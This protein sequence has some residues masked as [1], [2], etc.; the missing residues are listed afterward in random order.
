MNQKFLDEYSLT[1]NET[2][3]DVIKE[4]NWSDFLVFWGNLTENYSIE[5]ILNLFSYN[6]HGSV[7]YTFDEWN[8]STIDRRIKRS[9]K[10]IPILKNGFKTYV[11]DIKQTYQPKTSTQSFMLWYNHHKVDNLLIDYYENITDYKTPSNDS[12]TFRLYFLFL[13]QYKKHI[14]NNYQLNSKES[15][16]VYSSLAELLIVKCNFK[17]SNIPI[18]SH[19][20]IRDL[21]QDSLM[22]C[23]QIINK[24]AF[25]LF[26]EVK[27]NINDLE[28][29]YKNLRPLLKN[30]DTQLLFK[31]KLEELELNTKI[32]IEFINQLWNNLTSVSSSQIKK[33]EKLIDIVEQENIDTQALENDDNT[34]RKIEE[35]NDEIVSNLEKVEY[36]SNK[37]EM[38]QLS[39]FESSEDI[40]SR[41][42]CEIFNGFETIYQNTFEIESIE[43]KRWEHIKSKEKNLSV[44]LTSEITEI[45]RDN[46]FTYFNSN[47]DEEIKLN[48][49]INNNL[50]LSTLMVDKDFSIIFSPNLIHIYWHNFEKKQYDLNIDSKALVTD[51]SNYILNDENE[52]A[53]TTSSFQHIID[54]EDT[55]N[56][57]LPPID[58]ITKKSKDNDVIAYLRIGNPKQLLPSLTYH[59]PERIEDSFGAKGHFNDNL[60]AIKLLKQIENED[61]NAT[62]DEQ[63]IL[64]KYIGWGAMPSSFDENDK[65]WKKEYHEL[66]SLLTEE[67]YN[68]ARESTLTSFY[69]PTI[70]IDAMYKALQNMGFESGNLFDPCCATG[71]FFG[72][73]P[74]DLEKCKLYGV[75]KDSIS[76]R[77]AKLLYPKAN[78]EVNS[79]ED[80]PIEDN[81]FDVSIGNVPFGNFSVFD[82]RYKNNFLI[83]DYFFQKTIDKT[84]PNGL[85]AFITSS[86]TLDKKDNTIRKYIAQR[87]KFLGAIRLPNDT[88]SKNANTKVT[89][90][91]IFLQ[92]REELELDISNEEWLNIVENDD[93]ISI[94]QY[95]INHPNMML[96]TMEMV[97]SQFG[98]NSVLKPIENQD[99]KVSLNEAINYLPKNIFSKPKYEISNQNTDY[100]IL[101]VDSKIKND[102]FVIKI[103]NGK[104][105]IYQRQFSSLVP[106]TIQDGIVAKRIIELTKIKDA[107]KNNFEIQLKNGSDEELKASQEKLHLLYDSFIKKYG[108]INDRVNIRAYEE[109]PDCYLLTSIENM[110]RSDDE[111]EK[112]S[113]SKGDVFFK[114]T[115]NKPINIEV[116][117]SA[118]EALT[119]SM[120]QKGRV[121]IPFMKQLYDVSEEQLIEELDNLIYKDPMEENRYVTSS[122]YLSG[123][124]KEKLNIAE[125]SNI[126]G[127]YERNIIALTEVLP[128]KI[129]Y[130]DISVTLGS[131][132]I[133][134]D[135]YCDFI[136]QLLD[137]QY[138]LRNYLKIHYD[139]VTN[140]WLFQAANLYGRTIKNTNTWGTSRADALMIIK[141]TLN[142]KNITIFDKTEDEKFVINQNETIAAREKQELIKQ[143]F[144][145]WIW[146]DDVR[147]ERLVDI[148]NDTFN[149]IVERKY[150]GSN[151]EFT[152]MNPSVTL[153]P[154]QKNAVARVLLGGNTL[155]AHCVGAGKTYECIASVME[156]KKLQVINKPL[157]VVPNG[158]LGQWASEFLKLYPTANVLVATNKDFEVSR[159]RRLFG[160]IATGEW[161]AVI[162]AHSSFGLIPMSKEYQKEHIISEQKQ[163]IN[164]IQQIE[165][166]YGNNLSVKKLEQKRKSLDLKL[167]TLLDDDKKDIILNFEELGVD[168]LIV[169]EAHMFKNLPMYSKM[170]NVSGVN[171]CDSKKATDLFMK[172][173]YI[174]KNND[175][176]GILFATG[177]PISNSMCEL[178]AMQ[179]YLR[180]DILKKMNIY[181]FDEWASVFGETVNSFEIAPDGRGFQTR[182][183]FA[184]F[185]N[186]PELMSIFRQFADIQTTQMLK[187]PVPKLKNN[188]YNT[189]VAPPSEELKEYIK[190]LSERS[191]LVHSGGID[192]SQD[193]MLV[194]TNDGR[195]AALDLRLIDQN[196]PDI[197]NS[198]INLAVENIYRVWLETKEDSLTQL[199]FC[200]LSTPKNDGS[201]NV[202]DDI[203]YKLILKGI[204]TA[205]IEFIHDAKTNTQKTKLYDDIRSGKTRILIGSTAK[206]GAGM[207]VQ[208]K[209]IALHHLDCP[210]R[211]SDIE[212]RE[213]RILRRGNNNEEVEIYRYVTESSFDA[214]SYQLI[215]TKATFINQIMNYDDGTR[216]AEDL[217]RDTLTYAE[218]KAIAS[219]NPLVL[220][221]F[222]VDNELK[223]LYISKASYERAKQD[224][225]NKFEKELP[226]E[227]KLKNDML[228]NLKNDKEKVID[229]S[230]DNF[231]I[232]IRDVIYTTRKEASV[233]FYQCLSMLKTKEDLKIGEIS[234]FDIIGTREE[235]NYTPVVYIKANGKYKVEISNIN[236][237]GNILKLENILKSFESKISTFEQQIEYTS[238]QLNDIASELSKEFQHYDKIRELQKKKAEIDSKLDLDRQDIL[239]LTVEKE[240]DDERNLD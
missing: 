211:P 156:L 161:D 30:E 108:Y 42:I 104:E 113:Y 117:D 193:N 144:R 51:I 191:D 114:R 40:L 9:S 66:Q 168:Q 33:T 19:R 162:I 219:G 115:I 201:F 107:L 34:S 57:V 81:F 234:G 180:P 32:D 83:H 38:G 8:N 135:I 2:L 58:E 110:I 237:I 46:S 65:N 31:N 128:P 143:E 204:P 101:E 17:L 103:I 206:M 209:L 123:N 49:F 217:D 119:V 77:I 136:Y 203:K 7:F 29:I 148:Y 53:T 196:Y 86:G 44:C 218:V 225:K 129:N 69:T 231:T 236:E 120:N 116:V 170:T 14:A 126:N 68:D 226:R 97:S 224:L 50:F 154:H 197:T 137:I 140:E 16:F 92:K 134:N 74:T 55:I 147:K 146:K 235:L 121:D 102:A 192:P 27:D 222:K 215:Q 75:E 189:V 199:V 145:D 88:F 10:G 47:K 183:R 41:K 240:Q 166:S 220:E 160:K 43:L 64:A 105:V 176:R 45:D 141:N 164:S 111:T 12:N 213:G 22:K 200:D 106:Y 175:N 238:N 151:L 1:V 98:M 205:E 227:L 172:I 89:T 5:N 223:Q 112:P 188:K 4:E 182:T 59:L 155:L 239:V 35:S 216:S 127:E 232:K 36:F 60:N 76:G 179:K 178:F 11:F 118:S 6:P 26:N 93:E 174:L 163:I 130:D 56:T 54:N 99:L 195:K 208:D 84:I 139:T 131:T 125:S 202:Y 71:H 37:D 169:D 82:R 167:K 229:L 61:R 190:T 79:Y 138:G 173:S 207:N 25:S 72:R 21:S 23:M 221:K 132:W 95:Y 133:P 63:T 142:L 24:E 94:N 52:L 80:Y 210:W 150:D 149:C 13:N 171:N 28:F 48:D 158:L 177:T 124:I 159:R 67:E 15:E 212:Q 214:Y 96:G 3:E 165:S 187:L 122:E 184:K 20:I 194:I 70:V 87:A 109:D 233:K 100:E 78:I 157:F 181:H 185:N 152:G 228:V 85:I 62:N 198:K 39:L 186:I 153:L 230:G 90:D 18:F 91:I 73:L